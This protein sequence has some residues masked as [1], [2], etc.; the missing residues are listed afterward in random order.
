ML[1]LRGIEVEGFGPFAERAVLTFTRPTGRVTVVYGDN[2]RGKTS[3]MN[4][5]RYAFFGEVHR[6]RRAHTRNLVCVQPR[7]RRRRYVRLYRRAVTPF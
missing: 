6:A 5:I 2:M 1:T 4:A 3:L 7:P